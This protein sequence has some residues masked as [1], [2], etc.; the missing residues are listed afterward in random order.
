MNYGYSNNCCSCNNYYN[1]ND[2]DCAT[3]YED[4]LCV[5]ERNDGCSGCGNNCGVLLFI[6][7]VILIFCK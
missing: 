6:I 2:C 7:A 3:P 5:T 4:N 1:N